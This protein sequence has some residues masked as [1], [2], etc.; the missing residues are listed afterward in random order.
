MYA[1]FNGLSVIFDDGTNTLRVCELVDLKYMHNL[2][3]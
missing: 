3:N 2:H 1:T